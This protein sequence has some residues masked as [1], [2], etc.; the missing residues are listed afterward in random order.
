MNIEKI[1][2]IFTV[3]VIVIAIPFAII[4]SLNTLFALGLA[5]DMKTWL[6]TVILGSTWFGGGAHFKGDN[7]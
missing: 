1:C 6:A 4:W 7:S 2:K 5:Y 3:C